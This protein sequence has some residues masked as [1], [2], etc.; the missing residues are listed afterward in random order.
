M[1]KEAVAAF[2][3][4]SPNKL[5]AFCEIDPYNNNEVKGYIS[6]QSDYRYGALYI[7]HVNGLDCFQVILCTP[8]LK[9]PF[10]RVG[11]TGDRSYSWPSN[12]LD[13]W[14]YEKWDGTNICAYTYADAYGTRYVSYKTRL[15]PFVKNTRF[16]PF[17]DLLDECLPDLG[18]RPSADLNISFELCGYRN[19]H[20]IRYPFP[21]K[22]I[23]LFAISSGSIRPLGSPISKAHDVDRLT[24]HYESYRGHAEAQITHNEDGT[25]NGL[26]GYVLY[27]RTDETTWVMYKCKPPTVENVHWTSDTIPENIILPTVWNSLEL[28]DE[29]TVEIVSQMLLEEFDQAM[30]DKSIPRIESA[31]K[32]VEAHLTRRQSILRLWQT[33]E[34]P[35]PF[36]IRGYTLH[37]HRR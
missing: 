6:H 11:E 30:V 20:L 2:A 28:S 13:L 16:G 12:A 23:P 5:S 8:K 31:I 21:L 18:Y 10:G 34:L 19:M 24:F 15:N 3:Q 14:I 32:I 26:E 9:Y 7:T 4:V 17:K 37:G 27:V 1:D 35:T 36:R 22:L 25:L 33:L 29:P